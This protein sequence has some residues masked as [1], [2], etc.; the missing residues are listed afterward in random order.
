MRNYF[1]IANHMQ[2]DFQKVYADQAQSARFWHSLR[3]QKKRLKRCASGRDSWFQIPDGRPITEQLVSIG[4]PTHIEHRE[5]GSIISTAHK[6]AT[7][8]F[9]ER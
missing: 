7:F 9:V 2:D 8:S 4:W 3:C 1:G 5:Y 6:Y